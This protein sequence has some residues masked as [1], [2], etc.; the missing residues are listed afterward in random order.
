MRGNYIDF[1]SAYCDRWCERCAFTDRC[2]AYAVHVATAMCDG[3]FEAGLELA[4]GAPP[5]ADESERKRREEFLANLENFE[6][7]TEEMASWR[8][9]RAEQDERIGQL[10][11]TTTVAKATLLAGQWLDRHRP[12]LSGEGDANLTEAL[13][14]VSWDRYFIGAKLRRA[15]MGRDDHERD[16][17][18]ED[19]PVQSDWNGSAKVAL[20]SIV[21]SIEAWDLLAAS[22]GDPEAR[23]VAGEFRTLRQQVEEVFRDAWKFVRPGFDT[24]P[25]KPGGWP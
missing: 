25:L 17:L 3:D 2:S 11:V 20:I 7:T 5:P 15:L 24:E 19:D 13:D 23:Q 18:E 12:M 8:R 21:R 6:P 22:T 10:P 14:V 16:V 4:V 1:I 9:H